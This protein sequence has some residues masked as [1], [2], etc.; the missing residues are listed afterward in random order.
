MFITFEG[1]NGSGKSTQAKLLF[2]FL[3]KQ[4]KDVV[5]T[6]EP[7]GGGEFCTKLRRI[8]CET[9][10]ISKLTETFLLFAARKEHLDKLII[11]SLKDGKIVICDRYI[12]STFAY[13][14]NN[15]PD[16]IKFVE[17]LH[18]KI[19]GLMPD[20]TFYIDISVSESNYRL[21]E[22]IYESTM[23]AMSERSGYKKYDHL[24]DESM[25]KI[26]DSYRKI[27]ENNKQR[28]ITI[29]G[30]RTAEEIH[31]QIVKELGF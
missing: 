22:K 4:G 3:K 11:P 20:K 29:N 24:A 30:T 8:I 10:D 2:N 6:K 31:K 15:D 28:I 18:E 5:L 21:A 25:Q 13:Q 12:D 7:G 23:N 26:L 19:G 27:A 9:D 1:I 14:C 17:L 16:K